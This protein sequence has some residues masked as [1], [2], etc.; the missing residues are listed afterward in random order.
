MKYI[1]SREELR[2]VYSPPGELPLRKEMRRLDPTRGI[3]L[4]KARSC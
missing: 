1:E 4:S 3:F 2:K